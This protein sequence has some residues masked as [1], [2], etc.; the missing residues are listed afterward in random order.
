[1]PSS[2]KT[3]VAQSNTHGEDENQ[4]EEKHFPKRIRRNNTDGHTNQSQVKVDSASAGAS[5]STHKRL[6]EATTQVFIAEQW[7]SLS[8]TSVVIHL[9]CSICNLIHHSCIWLIVPVIVYK[10]TCNVTAL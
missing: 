3:F 6:S 2:N 7:A 5:K 1:M 4:I 9:M 10:H 8:I